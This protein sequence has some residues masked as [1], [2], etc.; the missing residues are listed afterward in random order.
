VPMANVR[1]AIN[2]VTLTKM[3]KVKNSVKNENDQYFLRSK[4][5]NKK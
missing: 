4:K 1:I 3:A 2:T 5:L